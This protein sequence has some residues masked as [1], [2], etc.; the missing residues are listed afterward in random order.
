MQPSLT[1]VFKQKIKRYWQVK[2]Q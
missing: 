1:N 2:L